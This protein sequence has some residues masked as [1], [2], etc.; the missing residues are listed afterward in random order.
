MEED[1][2]I[3]NSQKSSKVDC[4]SKGAD[5]SFSKIA[6]MTESGNGKKRAA[7]SQDVRERLS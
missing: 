2:F 1:F 3:D 7:L 6:T 4:E 5:I